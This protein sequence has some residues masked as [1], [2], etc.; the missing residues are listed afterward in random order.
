MLVLFTQ[1]HDLVLKLKNNVR[2]DNVSIMEFIA[3]VT[4][5][6][7]CGPDAGASRYFVDVQGA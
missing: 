5:E 3:G 7:C 1:M 4:R 2:A 6:V